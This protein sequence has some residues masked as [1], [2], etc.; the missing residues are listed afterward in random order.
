MKK[1][2]S[3][4]MLV[5]LLLSFA[6]SINA[7]AATTAACDICSS[8]TYIQTYPGG[9]QAPISTAI[10]YQCDCLPVDNYLRVSLTT[11]YLS[12]TQY[13][14]SS[15]TVSDGYDVASRTARQRRTG[16]VVAIAEYSGTCGVTGANITYTELGYPTG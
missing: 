5:V 15:P 1:F 6:A 4:I 2:V 9:A 7:F 13:Y 10:I 16:A 8:N 3:V 14:T 12:G 11:Q